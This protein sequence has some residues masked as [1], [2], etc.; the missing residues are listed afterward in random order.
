MIF[1]LSRS[2][3]AALMIA[4]GC[5]GPLYGQQSAFAAQVRKAYGPNQE[6]VNGVQYYNPHMQVENH[7]YFLGEDYMNGSVAINGRLFR[8]VQVRYDIYAQRLELEYETFSEATNSL[9]AVNDHIDGFS[10]GDHRF[11]K[12]ELEGEQKYCQVIE[13]E[14]FSCL[15]HWEKKLDRITY[16]NFYAEQFTDPSGHFLLQLDGDMVGFKNRR[17]FSH[18]FPE[19]SQK[20]IR[21][22]M[23]QKRF[24]FRKASPGEIVRTMQA[25]S[26]LLNSEPSP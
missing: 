21:R 1:D 22:L 19:S 11:L 25:V 12:M 10:I 4:V 6:L 2:A 9:V 17:A 3:L 13:T 20:Q 5:T 15:I 7:P 24:S 23:R 8:D 14:H 16:S 18:C 26:N